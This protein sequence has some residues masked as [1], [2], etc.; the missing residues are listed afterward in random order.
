MTLGTQDKEKAREEEQRNH[1]QLE[2]D[3][4]NSFWEI[5]K[6]E[7]D[8]K[9]SEVRNKD[10]EMEKMEECHQNE[11][12]AYKQKV[13]HLMYEHQNN[14]SSLKADGKNALKEQEDEFKGREGELNTDKRTLKLELREAELA[15]RDNVEQLKVNHQK[16]IDKLQEKANEKYE[17]L[18]QTYEKKM[19]DLREDLELRRKQEVNE[20]TE[21]KNKHINE[22]MQK[23]E[24]AF[25]EMKSYY[26]DVTHNNLDLI[27]TLKEDMA[28]MKKKEASNEKLMHEI[29]QENK[30]LHVPL[31]KA[32]KDVE[33]LTKQ[34]ANYDKDKELLK[35]TKARLRETEKALK[36]LEW[37][38]EVHQQRMDKI[39]EERDNLYNKFEESVRN[40][41]QKSGLKALMLEGKL[42][43]VETQLEEKEAQLGEVPKAA[44]LDE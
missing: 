9:K 22:L 18:R 44:N 30:R 21:R 41:Q 10:R 15:H 11:I 35:K 31:D 2:R 43:A 40:V 42:G 3:K 7:L 20:L 23:H 27:K 25:S 38:H 19:R 26:N 1:M 24:K 17:Q 33:S 6:K 29:A 16:T 28:G 36:N 37:E 13:K 8:D 14:I 32:T 39:Q 12:E 34:L 4:I 5:T